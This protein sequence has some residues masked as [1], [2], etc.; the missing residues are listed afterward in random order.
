MEAVD[1]R[2]AAAIRS[3]ASVSRRSQLGEFP[4]STVH[5][6]AHI[7]LALQ[8]GSPLNFSEKLMALLSISQ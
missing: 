3:N 7:L 5:C 6:G 4:N 1:T 8:P 2:M